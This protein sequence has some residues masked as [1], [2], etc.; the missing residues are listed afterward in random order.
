VLA[1]LAGLL[2]TDPA[3]VHELHRLLT[4]QIIVAISLAIVALATLAVALGVLFTVRKVAGTIAPIVDDANQVALSVRARVDTVLG[5]VD[6]LSDRLK[7]GAQAVEDRVRQFGTVVDVVQSEPENLLM[8][9]ASTAHGVHA[10]AARL[11][12]GKRAAEPET[13]DEDEDYDP[14]DEVFQD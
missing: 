12:T 14:E 4:T 3:V 10:A 1:V 2:Q 8:D 13:E 6:D 9:A 11:R 7:S 5:T